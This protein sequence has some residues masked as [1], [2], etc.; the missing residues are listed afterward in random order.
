[1]EEIAA[2]SPDLV[3]TFSDVQAHLSAELI[4]RG[5]PVL[6]TNQRTL[7]ET[8]ATLSLLGRVVGRQAEAERQL[9][10]FRERLAPTKNI[11]ARPRVYFEEWDDPFITGIG[12]VGELI[13]RAGGND[14]FADLRAQRAAPQRVVSSEQICRADPE[15][16]VASWCGKPVQ[17]AAISSRPGWAKLAAVCA[18]RIYEIPGDD[19][20]QPG[21]RLVNGYER[22]KEL[23]RQE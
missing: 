4:K 20:L 2:L 16:I 15:I 12:W 9:C 6:A 10:E 14:I 13:E 18:R 3:V 7:A 11:A 1:L 8:E 23:L 5:F 17:S 21:F 19:I 22:L